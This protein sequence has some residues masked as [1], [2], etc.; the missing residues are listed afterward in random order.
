M[1]NY[2][3]NLGNLCSVH[4]PSKPSVWKTVMFSIPLLI[5]AALC[6][7]IT[8][9]SFTGVITGSKYRASISVSSYFVCTGVVGLLL[10][11]LGSLL[12][13]DCRAWAAT[14]TVKLTIYQEGFAYESWGRIE[15][16]LW[17]E[18]EKFKYKF[19]QIISKALRTRVKV[20]RAIV[21]K[22][23]TEI[24]LAETLDLRQITPL[25]TA[26]KKETD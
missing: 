21:K 26:A 17:E 6:T 2:H 24:K 11:F 4:R 9:D 1:K 12:V 22:D 23:G 13:S 19:V 25:I 5:I 16:C 10:A 3:P 20:I 7:A 8:L 18:I 15:T 14:K